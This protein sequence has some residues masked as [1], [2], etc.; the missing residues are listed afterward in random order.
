MRDVLLFSSR[1][2]SYEF[3]NLLNYFCGNDFKKLLSIA[4]KAFWTF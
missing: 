2:F 4:N 3:G 1:S